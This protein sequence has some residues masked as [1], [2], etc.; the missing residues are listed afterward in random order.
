[1]GALSS[2]LNS[3]LIKNSVLALNTH[4]YA[5]QTIQNYMYDLRS[6]TNRVKKSLHCLYLP[7]NVEM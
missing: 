1:M 6:Y 3:H 5:L 7:K 4:V 2:I